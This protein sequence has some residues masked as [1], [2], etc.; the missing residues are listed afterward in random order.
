MTRNE[1]RLAVHQDPAHPTKPYVVGVE[2][3]PG[4]FQIIERYE[5]K[6][7]ADRVCKKLLLTFRKHVA[8]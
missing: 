1:L 4:K 2:I 8:S 5:T 6:V 3:A 7:A